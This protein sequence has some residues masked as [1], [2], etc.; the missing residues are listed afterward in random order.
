[1]GIPQPGRSEQTRHMACT[2]LTGRDGGRRGWSTDADAAVVR[3]EPVL[4]MVVGGWAVRGDSGG[5][6]E[7]RAE[8]RSVVI[9]VVVHD[10]GLASYLV[11]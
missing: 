6:M 3:L 1:M 9:A 11:S 10:D 8:W 4:E 7:R 5:R 2:R